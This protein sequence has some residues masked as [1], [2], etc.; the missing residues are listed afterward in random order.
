MNYEHIPP[1]LA[2]EDLMDLVDRTPGAFETLMRHTDELHTL[3]L[4]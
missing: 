1:G 4:S 2:L 3:P